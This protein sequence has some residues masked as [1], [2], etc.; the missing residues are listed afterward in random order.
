MRGL[1]RLAVE[2]GLA[3]VIGKRRTPAET[4]GRSADAPNGDAWLTALEEAKEPWFWYSTGAG[5]N[6]SDRAWIDDLRLPFNAMRGYVERL[7]A[8]EDIDRPLRRGHRE[9]ARV[10]AEYRS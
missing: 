2:L 6:H 5:Y 7:E 3:D 9:R 4:L 10:T 8:G 1:A